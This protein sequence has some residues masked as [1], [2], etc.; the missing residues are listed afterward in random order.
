MSNQRKKIAQ[1][2]EILKK[3]RDTLAS[4]LLRKASLGGQ[5][6]TPPEV[7]NGI[8]E[9]RAEIPRI[10]KI[11]RDWGA[12]V[13]DH[14]DDE[15]T[16]F[17]DLSV[18]PTRSPSASNPG[19]S[20]QTHSAGVDREI[21]MFERETNELGA[22]SH[23]EGEDIDR[24]LAYLIEKH[25]ELYHQLEAHDARRQKMEDLWS[26]LERMDTQLQQQKSNVN[27]HP[28]R[29]FDD[30]FPEIDFVASERIFR[31]TLARFG[32]KGGGAVFLA[33]NG[34]IMGGEWLVSRMKRLLIPPD[35]LKTFE[36]EFLQDDFPDADVFLRRLGGRLG[37]EPKP[38]DKI[39]YADKIIINLC[40]PQGLQHSSIVLIDLRISYVPYDDRFL[41]W[42]VD[43]F[44][45]KIANQLQYISESLLMVKFIALI[46]VACPISRELLSSLRSIGGK[47]K[48]KNIILLPLSNWQQ[49]DIQTWLSNSP[50]GRTES[51]LT[52]ERIAWIAKSIYASSA[53][54]MPRLIH[55]ALKDYWESHY[56]GASDNERHA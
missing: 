8:N 50:L 12:E 20:H 16:S 49:N 28:F 36:I 48:S 42:F 29:E 9:A 3:W 4:L 47:D 18:L 25:A 13:E 27:F 31:N 51:G 2:R 40:H 26:R 1:Q 15:E 11:L 52:A 32:D 53:N 22:L 33:R 10:K 7:V 5:A 34:H 39:P 55:P 45:V 30:H 21:V 35:R 43:D 38:D 41:F 6:Y 23:F 19:I 46:V 17:T 44:W 14:P 24:R 37:I 54:G 56:G